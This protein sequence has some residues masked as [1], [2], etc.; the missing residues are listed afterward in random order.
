MRLESEQI[1]S[2]QKP[3]ELSSRKRHRLLVRF[4]WPWEAMFLEALVPEHEAVAFPVQDLH[5]VALAVAEGKELRSEGV[6]R[7]RLLDQEG[8]AIDGLAI[9]RRS[10]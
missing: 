7:K 2:I 8:E 5:L 10:A 1:D 3:V 6:E 9:M 4:S